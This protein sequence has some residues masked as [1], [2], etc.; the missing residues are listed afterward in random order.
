MQT[1]PPDKLI[2]LLRSQVIPW[3][4]SDAQSNFFVAH[5]KARSVE[6][7]EHVTLSRRKLVGRRVV[8]KNQRNYSNRRY[9]VADWPDDNLQEIA[10]PKLVC[11]VSGIADYLL[12][13]YCAHCPSK[14]FFLV[15][16]LVPHQ[17]KAPNLQGERR[18]QGSCVLLQ[19][20]VYTHGVHFWY[21]RSVNEHHISE[22]EDHYVIPS[23]TAAQTLRSLAHEAMEDKSD[24][25]TVANSFIAA[26]FAILAR[27]IE[28]GNYTHPGPQKNAPVPLHVGSF[29]EQVH[30]YLEANCHKQL[31]LNNVAA[32]MLMSRSQ[33]ARRM[34]QEMGVTFVE[35]LT[36]YRI[37][38]ACHM[39]SE[40]EYT[41]TAI[42]NTLGFFP[43]HIFNRFFV[44][45]WVAHQWNIAEKHVCWRLIRFHSLWDNTGV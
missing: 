22:A 24:L 20:Y 33:F 10:F 45:A 4:M 31:R 15:P 14:T 25:A 32:D 38:R 23:L 11:I 5:E 44:P 40:T 26:F 2:H 36:R 9:F 28:A 27:E 41:F 34:R 21:S 18:R 37:E 17:N 29:P 6:L 39:L 43:P 42:T 8:V 13:D 30:Q 19:A 7:P 16:P 1:I 12:G 3:A 35:L